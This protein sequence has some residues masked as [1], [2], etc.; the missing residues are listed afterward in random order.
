MSIRMGQDKICRK[1]NRRNGN[2]LK[3]ASSTKKEMD[4]FRVKGCGENQ[5]IIPKNKL[6]K[7]MRM[8]AVI[9]MFTSRI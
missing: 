6:N 4:Y 3:K 2:Y 1:K 8:W 9:T 5:R 7:C